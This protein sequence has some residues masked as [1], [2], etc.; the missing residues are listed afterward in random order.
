MVGGGFSVYANGSLNRAIQ[1]ASNT[2]N[3]NTPHKTAA[4]GMIYTNGSVYASLIDKFVGKTYYTANAND[5]TPIGG[6]AVTNFTAS[7]K[8]DPHMT[9]V[10]DFKVGFQINN[11]FNNTHID[12]LAGTTVADSTPLFWTI[13]ARNF[14]FTVSA[15]L[16]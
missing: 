8:F 4:L 6:Y 13:P 3:P 12:A 1:T 15:D 11:L 9:D 5:D 7:Y 16:F 14:N 10:K 2:W